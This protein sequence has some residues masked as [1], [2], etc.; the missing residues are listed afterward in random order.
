VVVFADGENI[1]AR[2]IEAEFQ[3]LRRRASEL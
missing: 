2:M 1:R 3:R